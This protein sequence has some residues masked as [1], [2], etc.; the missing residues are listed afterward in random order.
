M[1]NAMYATGL[2]AFATGAINWPS[3]GI[4]I[5]AVL[6]D[7]T[8]YTAN[9]TTDQF[10]S[11]IASPARV[12]TATVATRTSTGGICFAANTLFSAVSG[13]TV[14]AVVIY[15]NTGT[16]STSQ[17]ICYLDTLSGI[18]VTPNG[19]NILIQ[20]DAVNGIFKI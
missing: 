18:P 12:A 5:S 8:K 3:G 1:S 10:L 17:L 4:T 9:L 16:D 11:I 20:W 6:L 2:N 7:L 15:V 19:S 13:A 14:G